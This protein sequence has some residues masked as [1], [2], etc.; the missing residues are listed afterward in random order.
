MRLANIGF[1][2]W[3]VCLCPDS[4]DGLIGH[5]DVGDDDD[6][7]DGDDDDLA[8]SQRLDC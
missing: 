6:G 2:D 4:H 5:R 8:G 7:D 3:I 1:A